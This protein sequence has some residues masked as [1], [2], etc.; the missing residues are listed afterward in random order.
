MWFGYLY[1]HRCKKLE[2][3]YFPL[4]SWNLYFGSVNLGTWPTIAF[5]DP[6][7]WYTNS[8]HLVHEGSW[9]IP[10]EPGKAWGYSCSFEDWAI[11]K[12]VEDKML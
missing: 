7:E 9:S 11:Y 2:C 3:K 12:E 6:S 5:S 10:K 4:Y 8:L 1:Y